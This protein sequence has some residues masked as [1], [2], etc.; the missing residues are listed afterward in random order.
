MHRARRAFWIIGGV[1]LVGIGTLGIFVPLLPTTIFYIL[2]AACF[3]KSHPEWA[4][5]LYQHPKYGHHLR[6]WRDRKAISRKG[7][8]AAILTMSLSVV[9]V[10]FTAGGWWTLI[11]LAVL[12]TIG[13]W[14]WTR[15]E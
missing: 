12:A 9:A 11:P 13:T 14:I 3:S 8:I 2:A 15:A 6:E 10:W 1:I 5:R 7:K 4:E